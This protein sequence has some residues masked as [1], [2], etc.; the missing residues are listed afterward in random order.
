MEQKNKNSNLI[1]ALSMLW[2]FALVSAQFIYFMGRTEGF[3][4]AL[5]AMISYTSVSVTV[6]LCSWAAGRGLASLQF[7][8]SLTKRKFFLIAILCLF[9][10][11]IGL[12]ILFG[13]K[14]KELDN[15]NSHKL[16]E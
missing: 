12:F 8:T 13:T 11:P 7:N 1:F 5:D 15:N 16:S 3:E 2:G 14:F 4:S 6:L 10:F 9:F